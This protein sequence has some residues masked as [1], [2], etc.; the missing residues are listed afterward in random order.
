MK[1]RRQQPDDDGGLDS[2]LDTMTNVVGI[3]VLVLIVTQLGVSDKVASITEKSDVTQQD[4]DDAKHELQQQQEEVAALQRQAAT[5]S[6]INIEGERQRLDRMRDTIRQRQQQ[7]FRQQEELNTFAMQ[8]ETRRKRAA[9]IQKESEEN[10][11]RRQQLDT[12]IKAALERRT[13]LTAML[14]ETRQLKAGRKLE[15]RIPFPRPAP[16]QAKE[17][18]FVCTNERLFPARLEHHR[19]YAEQAAKNIIT[20]FNLGLTPELG[21]DPQKFTE[22]FVKVVPPPDDFFRAEYFVANNRWPRIRFHPILENGS[23]LRSVRRPTSPIRKLI[24]S[25]DPRQM[26]CRFYVLPDSYELY[27]SARRAVGN[28]QLLAG[29]SPQPANWTLTTHVPGIELGPPRPKPPPPANPPPRP[30]IID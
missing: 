11:K 20:L 27:I 15:V 18:T 25:L 19:T 6:T 17:A 4:V 9:E 2:L 30:K 7:N 3:L 22:Q 23:S 5:L 29:W 26:Y 13:M 1:V 10:E 24:T 21:I 28:Q 12:E 14:D 16:P 8:I